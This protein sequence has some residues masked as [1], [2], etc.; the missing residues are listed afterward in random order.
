MMGKSQI[1]PY[2]KQNFLKDKKAW[3]LIT[4]ISMTLS[5]CSLFN[6]LNARKLLANCK[7]ELESIDVEIAKFRS[8]IFIGEGKKKSKVKVSDGWEVIQEHW[9]DIKRGHFNLDFRKLKL[10]ANLI[11]DNPNDQYVVVDSLVVDAFMSNGEAFTRIIHNH[12]LEI[13]SKK[14]AQTQFK[15]EIPLEIGLNK[16]MDEE[17][18]KFKGTVWSK[19]K[20]TEGFSTTI[21]LPVEFNQKVPRKKLKTMI[22]QQKKLVFKQFYK[23]VENATWL[24]SDDIK[25]LKKEGQ[26]LLKGLF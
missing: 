25:S 12:S 10:K 2:W 6:S 3:L 13:P 21:P 5:A 19:L 24:K 16:L 1:L 9:S 22:D 17:V 15:V 11:I 14:S 18:I 8:A 4:L 23:K 26:N 7:Y 20:L